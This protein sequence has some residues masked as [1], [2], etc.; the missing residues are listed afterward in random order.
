MRDEEVTYDN[1][2]YFFNKL[3]ME[4]NEAQRKMPA[5]T[6][7]V[8]FCYYSGHGVQENLTK[9]IISNPYDAEP[10]PLED[11]LEMFS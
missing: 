3:F 8:F 7:F 11:K 2:N 9:I 10:Y 5:K 4:I 1:L 6:K